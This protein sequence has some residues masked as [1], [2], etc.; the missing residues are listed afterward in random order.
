MGYLKFGDLGQI[1]ALNEVKDKPISPITAMHLAYGIK[2][3]RQC[4]ACRH[5]I[6]ESFTEVRC[7][8]YQQTADARG[9][10]MAQWH[11]CG[12]WQRR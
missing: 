9:A 11:A 3:G 2:A 7:A 5:Y 4:G 1:K 12:K 6:L 10:W 8:I